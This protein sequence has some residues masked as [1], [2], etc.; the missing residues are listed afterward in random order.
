MSD[1][2]NDGRGEFG[3][4]FLNAILHGW[5]DLH[6]IHKRLVAELNSCERA[7][8]ELQ[9]FDDWQKRWNPEDGHTSHLTFYPKECKCCRCKP[10]QRPVK[11]P[12]E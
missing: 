8:V 12:N 5:L 4:H 11:L 9:K 1:K 3:N 7:I 10:V 6:A 2:I